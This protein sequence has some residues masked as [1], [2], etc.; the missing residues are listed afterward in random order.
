MNAAVND[1]GG[2]P[3]GNRRRPP[4]AAR[5]PQSQRL[6]QQ[7]KS[8]ILQRGLKVG[9]PLPTELDLIEQLGA[10]RSSVREALK[11]LQALGIIEIRHGY[12]MYVSR[13]SLDALVQ[14]LSFH[15]RISLT[16]QVSNLAD[17]VEIRQVLELGLVQ[18]LIDRHADVDLSEAERLAADMAVAAAAGPVPPGLDQAFHEA[19]YEPLRNPLAVEL[20]GAFWRAYLQVQDVLG[21]VDVEFVQTAQQ[22][23]EIVSAIRAGDREAANHAVI[24]HFD[25]L[26]TRLIKLWSANLAASQDG[27]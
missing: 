2:A 22:H 10:G 24:R 15:G 25:D 4:N 7:I 19:L 16:D 23:G 9:D 13:M 18:L 12:G 3:P 1:G 14:G 20:L 26:R 17:L 5:I 11:A 21:P 6:Q 27:G 8:L